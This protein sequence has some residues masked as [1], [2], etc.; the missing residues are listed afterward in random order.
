MKCKDLG[1]ALVLVFDTGD[2]VV[3]ELTAFAKKNQIKAGHFTAI[4]GFRDVGLGYFDVEKKAYLRNQVDEQVE[5]LSLIGDIALD[6][7][8]PK[9]H[10]HV[11]IGKRDGSAMGGHLMEAHVRPTLELM[12]DKSSGQL[13]RKMDPESGLALIRL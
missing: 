2:E 11:V 3:A 8:D 5:V 1:I 6:G 10:A 13:Q 12:L 7:N 4:G 9:I